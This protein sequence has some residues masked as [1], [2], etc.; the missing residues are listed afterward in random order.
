VD[1]QLTTFSARK[2]RDAGYLLDM[3][4]EVRIEADANKAPK[5]NAG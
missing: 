3:V 1:P 5:S 4:E 2:R